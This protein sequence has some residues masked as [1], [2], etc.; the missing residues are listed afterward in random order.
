MFSQVIIFNIFLGAIRA[1]Y[2]EDPSVHPVRTEKCEP[3][4]LFLGEPAAGRGRDRVREG[5]GCLG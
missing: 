3:G 2:F 1:T 5:V 4:I